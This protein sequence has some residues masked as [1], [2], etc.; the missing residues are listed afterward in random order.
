MPNDLGNQFLALKME[1]MNCS[2]GQKWWFVKMYLSF[3]WSSYQSPAHRLSLYMQIWGIL[4]VCAFCSSGME[5]IQEYPGLSRERGYHQAIQLW[6]D[7]Y[8]EYACSRSWKWYC[9]LCANPAVIFRPT[10]KLASSANEMF[11]KWLYH[12][13]HLLDKVCFPGKTSLGWLLAFT[14]VCLQHL[15]KTKVFIWAYV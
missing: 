4:G 14:I 13:L 6:Q 7:F 9:I 8:E 5:K 15:L 12:K 11:R 1:W 10:V 2:E 3:I